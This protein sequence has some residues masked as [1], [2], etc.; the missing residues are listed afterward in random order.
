MRNISK[1]NLDNKDLI[2]ENAHILI[3]LSSSPLCWE[4]SMHHPPLVVII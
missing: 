2:L 4:I 1:N 3:F